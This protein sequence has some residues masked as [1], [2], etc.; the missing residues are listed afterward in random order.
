MAET[1]RASANDCPSTDVCCVEVAE[2]FGVCLLSAACS[3]LN[4]GSP[5]HYQMCN[6]S[7]E[8]CGSN[9]C[10]PE[11]CTVGGGA[12]LTMTVC[13]G[14]GEPCTAGCKPACALTTCCGNLDGGA[15]CEMVCPF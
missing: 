1:A 12:E 4:G 15:T 10:V 6:V 14:V 9:P 8:A 3:A 5:P 13:S 7:E 11:Y 2:S